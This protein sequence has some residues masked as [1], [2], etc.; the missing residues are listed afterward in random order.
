MGGGEEREGKRK[1]EREGPVERKDNGRVNSFAILKFLKTINK[2]L[3][4][5]FIFRLNRRNSILPIAFKYTLR[6]AFNTLQFL[7]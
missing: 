4:Q 6:I 2:N 7:P 3:L 1:K 5:F